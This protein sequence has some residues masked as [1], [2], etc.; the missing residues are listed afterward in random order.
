MN[1]GTPVSEPLEI[2][3]PEPFAIPVEAPATP[4]R[5]PEQVPA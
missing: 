2:P 1:I 5:E 3:E 4:Q